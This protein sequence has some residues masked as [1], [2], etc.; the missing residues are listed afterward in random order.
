MSEI[1]RKRGANQTYMTREMH[2]PMRETKRMSGMT[3]ILMRR[4]YGIKYG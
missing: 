1:G 4:R 2:V 3:G